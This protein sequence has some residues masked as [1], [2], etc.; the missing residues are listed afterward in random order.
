MCWGSKGKLKAEPQTFKHSEQQYCKGEKHKGSVR[1][2]MRSEKISFRVIR[3]QER[4]QGK[5]TGRSYKE[6]F[7]AEDLT[8]SWCAADLSLQD[9]VPREGTWKCLWQG[10]PGGWQQSPAQK[11]T[12]G[13]RAKDKN[14]SVWMEDSHRGHAEHR[15]PRQ[16]THGF[17]KALVGLLFPFQTVTLAA[18]TYP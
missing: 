4:A 7:I 8:S 2:K 16:K 18:V 5:K 17:F 1:F 12:P 13:N 9:G 15:G 10:M 3:R 6:K 14:I 11:L